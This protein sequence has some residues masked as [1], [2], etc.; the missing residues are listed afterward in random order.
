MLTP[1][2]TPEQQ[3]AFDERK[4][5][6]IVDGHV[7]EEE[8]DAL[9]LLSVLDILPLQEEENTCELCGS[10]AIVTEYYEEFNMGEKGKE[11]RYI[12]TCEQCGAWRFNIDRTPLIGQPFKYFLNWQK[13]GK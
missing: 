2:L 13:K 8:V 3:D 11:N 10:S 7:R 9:A 12:D 6:M 1:L 5:I 4:A